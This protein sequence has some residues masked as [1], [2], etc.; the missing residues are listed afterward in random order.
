MFNFEAPIVKRRRISKS[1]LFFGL[2]AAALLGYCG[3]TFIENG[4][5]PMLEK[6]IQQLG[7]L[8]YMTWIYVGVFL[9]LG[10]M[11][12]P[13]IYTIFRKKVIVGGA[14][15]FDEKTLKIT[16]GKDQYIIPEEQLNQVNFELKPLPDPNRLEEGKLFGGS[17]MKI[18]TKQGTFE[19]E[20][21]IDNQHQKDQLLEMIEFL[22]IEHD[23][24]VKLTESK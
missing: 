2:I 1:S 19:C 8:S 12:L 17:W 20:L 23:V 7:F 16:K 18:P 21:N 3:L 22:K 14:V 24:Q 13:A 11:V 10:L 4:Y 9:S 6:L 15:S 5:I